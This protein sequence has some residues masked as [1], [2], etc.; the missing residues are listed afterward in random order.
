MLRAELFAQARTLRRKIAFANPL[1][2]FDRVLFVKH[3]I[4]R[5]SHAGAVYVRWGL[6]S[7]G[8]YELSGAFWPQPEARNVSTG[9]GSIG[10]LRRPDTPE[11]VL[12]VA[13]TLL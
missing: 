2:D 7:E 4:P 8:L 10:D 6:P 3:A 9:S 5:Q 12:H 11:R 13:G 1:L